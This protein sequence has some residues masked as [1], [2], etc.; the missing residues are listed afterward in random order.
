MP[1]VFVY[2]PQSLFSSSWDCNVDFQEAV[3]VIMVHDEIP[4]F[5]DTH[6][7]VDFVNAY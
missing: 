1:Q 4:S 2:P 5:S 3:E 7:D 6:V